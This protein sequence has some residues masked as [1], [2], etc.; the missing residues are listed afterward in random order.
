FTITTCNNTQI[1]SKYY[2]ILNNIYCS[3]KKLV[4]KEDWE[5]AM[6]LFRMIELIKVNTEFCN[7]EKAKEIYNLAVRFIKKLK[8]SCNE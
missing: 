6:E 4:E 2:Y 1:L 7:F 8:C 5:N 3:Y